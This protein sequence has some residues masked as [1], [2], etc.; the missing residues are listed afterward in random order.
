MRQSSSFIAA[1]P[2]AVAYLGPSFLRITRLQTAFPIGVWLDGTW[3]VLAAAAALWSAGGGSKG[4]MRALLAALSGIALGAAALAAVSLLRGSAAAGWDISPWTAEAALAAYAAFGLLWARTFGVADAVVFTRLGVLASALLLLEFALA[5]G[6]VAVGR[7][8]AMFAWSSVEACL[9]LA[10]LCFSFRL[11]PSI[12]VDQLLILTGVAATLS[13]PSILCAAILVGLLSPAKA[14]TR[15][16][17]VVILVVG[18]FLIGWLAS[19][20]VVTLVRLDWYWTWVAGV[21]ALAAHPHALLTGFPLDQAAPVAVKAPEILVQL[22]EN[23]A[24]GGAAP[25]LPSTF[26]PF[27][28]RL[29]LCWGLCPFFLFLLGYPIWLGR[30]PSKPLAGLFIVALI[31][32]VVSPLLYHPALGVV[33]GAALAAGAAASGPVAAAA[34]ENAGTVNDGGENDA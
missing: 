14:R 5:G 34:E 29:S 1:L 28:L 16:A 33:V 24:P 31:G 27:W 21:Q 32:G 7:G 12:S 23:V 18:I 30:R 22:W 26:G 20:P 15:T 4:W 10:S 19:S 2:L 6:S 13:R 8:S 3:V 17:V 25:S 9:L 11:T